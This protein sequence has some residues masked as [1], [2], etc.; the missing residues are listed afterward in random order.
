MT[1]IKLRTLFALLTGATLLTGCPDDEPTPSDTEGTGTGDDDGGTMPP[2]TM[3]P[4]T[5]PPTT[6]PT[7]GTDDT[8]TPMTDDTGTPMT[9][10]GMTTETGTPMTDDGSSSSEGGSESEDTGTTGGM[11]GGEY[12]PCQAD[13]DCLT[14]EICLFGPG[15][16]TVCAEDMCGDAGD[17]GTPATGD[18]TVTCSDLTGGG[19]NICWLDCIGGADCPDGMVCE[20]DVCAWAPPA[21]PAICGTGAELAGCDEPAGGKMTAE[22]TLAC[23]PAGNNFV[24]DIYEIDVT[25]GD[26]IFL[27]A[28][29]I[30]AGGPTGVAAADLI[31]FVVDANGDFTILDD[32]LDC[33]DPTFGGDFGCPEGGATAAST[34]TMMIGIAQYG[35]AGCPDPAPYTLTLGVNGAEVD[36]GAP[37]TQDQDT[38]C[39]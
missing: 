24:F 1:S 12:G 33:S 3:P 30:G 37:A 21:P 18:A 39:G 22:D 9:D 27:S 4:T 10:D 20:A 14:G 26:C 32:E 16:V 25:A 7:P 8:G 15:G 34:G 5:M 38:N 13:E 17:C 23:D 2:T 28:D 35:G 36:P 11:P 19:T 6:D 31:A 29:N